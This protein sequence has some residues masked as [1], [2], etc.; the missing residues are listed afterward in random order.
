[1]GPLRF[2]KGKFD[3]MFTRSF[4]LVNVTFHDFLQ[5]N[6]NVTF[7]PSLI[8]QWSNFQILKDLNGLIPQS[9]KFS[10]KTINP[11]M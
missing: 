1:M 5:D 9:E 3:V 11:Q 8:N 2:G 6:V 7:A 4:Y 10:Y